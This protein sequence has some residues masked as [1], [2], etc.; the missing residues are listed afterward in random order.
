[1]CITPRIL[2]LIKDATMGLKGIN[3]RDDSMRKWHYLGMLQSFGFLGGLIFYR[4][5]CISEERFLQ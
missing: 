5:I 4:F 3:V 1:L 2:N